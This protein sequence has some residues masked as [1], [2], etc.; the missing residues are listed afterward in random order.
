MDSFTS[1]KTKLEATG[2]YKIEEGSNIFAEL[3]AYA[4]GIEPLFE[5]LDKMLLELFIDTAEDYGLS[6]REELLG[7]V[8]NDYPIDRRRE[9]LKIY[10]Q[11]MGGKC[12][13]EAFEM[14]L[15]GYGL[16]DFQILEY[17]L[18]KRVVIKVNDDVAPELRKLVEE[19]V[20]L[21]FPT[22]LLVTVSYN[23]Q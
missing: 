14:V 12:T 1:M 18:H 16:S 9:M 10:E 23:E 15:R 4:A 7:K 8:K 11:M 13:Q 5:T 20:A 17:A 19:R 6:C 21:D 2:L 3:S 22:H